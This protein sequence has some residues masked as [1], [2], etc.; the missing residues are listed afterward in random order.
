MKPN[1]FYDD[2]INELQLDASKIFECTNGTL[3]TIL[4]LFAEKETW[5]VLDKVKGVP[6]IMF[7]GIID[8][9]LKSLNN[10]ESVIKS[11]LINS[12]SPKFLYRNFTK[13]V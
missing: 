4:Q 13:L 8:T 2:C 9:D 6:A 10:F 12:S 5:K 1:H 11:K 7:D 3:G